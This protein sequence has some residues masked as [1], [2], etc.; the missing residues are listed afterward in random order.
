MLLLQN[1]MW[2]CVK[3]THLAVSC[4][5]L[6]MHTMVIITNIARSA[7]CIAFI[8]GVVLSARRQLLTFNCNSMMLEIKQVNAYVC[9]KVNV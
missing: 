6:C 9:I 5:N 7:V 3:A 1:Q 8:S 4:F 2:L